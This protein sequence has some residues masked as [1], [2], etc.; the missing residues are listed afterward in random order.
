VSVLQQEVLSLRPVVK[1]V[2]WAT[3]VG[4][5]RPERGVAAFGLVVLELRVQELAERAS[6]RVLVLVPVAEWE[7]PSSS[8]ALRQV[9]PLMAWLTAR[10]YR[11]SA[12]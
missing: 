6:V 4:V 10:G 3:V 2:R 12:S 1:V 8:P 9:Q 7:Y 11:W 5:A